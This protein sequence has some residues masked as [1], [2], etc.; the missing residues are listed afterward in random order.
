MNASA[1]LTSAAT[2]ALLACA[3][4]SAPPVEPPAPAARSEQPAPSPT[5]R[6]GGRVVVDLVGLESARGQILITLFRSSQGFPDRGQEAFANQVLQARTGT[7]QTVFEPVPPGPF[8]VSVHHD[9]DADYA[10]DTGMFGVPEEG[11]GFSRD[12]RAPFGPPDFTAA[13]VV[14]A[15]GEQKRLVI[16]LRY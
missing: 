6:S 4:A 12:A 3:C 5:A 7:V 2:A 8:A 14:L 1:C 9:E 16:H 10:M 11:Y 13:R 15:E